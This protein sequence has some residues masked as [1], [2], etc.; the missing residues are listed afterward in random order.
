MVKSERQRQK[1]A[2]AKKRRERK[3]KINEA[4]KAKTRETFAYLRKNAPMMRRELRRKGCDWKF[5]DGLDSTVDALEREKHQALKGFPSL[6]GIH[7][8]DDDEYYATEQ[9]PLLERLGLSGLDPVLFNGADVD[10]DYL[11]CDRK[12]NINGITTAFRDEAG[13]LKTLVLLRNKVPGELD[14]ESKCALKLIALFHEIGHVADWEQGVNLREGDISVLDAEVY[15]NKYSLQR[16]MDGDYRGA[17][18]IL[19]RALE[20]TRIGQDYRRAVADRLAESGVFAKCQ[21]FAKAKWQDYL[22][23]D[24]A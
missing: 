15:A 19:L 9:G 18:G 14:R 23:A 3:R 20:K 10:V 21:D 8:V 13:E 17:L 12:S 11:A 4:E 6:L 1:K 2:D 24:E 16:L 7:E 22:D 5:Y